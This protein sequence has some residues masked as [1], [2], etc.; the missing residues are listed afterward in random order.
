MSLIRLLRPAGKV[1]ALLRL[2]GP[3]DDPMSLSGKPNVLT[4]RCHAGFFAALLFP[5][6]VFAH[7]AD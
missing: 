4:W 2:A 1:D 6:S 5:A 3:G 7:N